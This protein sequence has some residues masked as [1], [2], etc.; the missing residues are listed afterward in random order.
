MRHATNMM[1]R[2]T[3]RDRSLPV[4][5]D[6]QKSISPAERHLYRRVT[7]GDRFLE[8]DGTLDSVTRAAGPKTLVYYNREMMHTLIRDDACSLVPLPSTE[9][10]LNWKVPSYILLRKGHVKLKRRVNDV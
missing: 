6:P 5:R 8:L 10:P 3:F 4:S 9:R 7:E 1:M 2:V